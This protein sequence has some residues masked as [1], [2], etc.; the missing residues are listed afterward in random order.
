MKRHRIKDLIILIYFYEHNE[1]SVSTTRYYLQ[2][3][4]TLNILSY[5]YTP[6]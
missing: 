1:W 4:E 2:F 3:K 5:M 6:Q